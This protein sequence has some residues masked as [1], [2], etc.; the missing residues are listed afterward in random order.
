VEHKAPHSNKPANLFTRFNIQLAKYGMYFSMTGLF[1]IIAIVAYQV[2]G[3]YV[4][5][6]SPT[7][8]ENLALVLILY[9]TLIGAAVGVRD[10]GHIGM[11]SIIVLLPEHI[12]HK[13]EMVIHLCVAVFGA[14]M[15]YNGYILGA[16]VAGY[17]LANINLSEAWRY[18]P[19]VFSGALIILFSLEH[20]L[21]LIDGTEVEPTWS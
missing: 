2:F 13:I 17:K 3:R 15:I 7:W 1:V 4:L 9:V 5:N 16:S 10:A 14:A 18:V 20:L 19:L 6:D 8:A 21:A 11:E 12:R